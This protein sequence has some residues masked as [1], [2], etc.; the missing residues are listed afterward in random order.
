MLCRRKIEPKLSLASWKGPG[1]R[2]LDGTGVPGFGG[3]GLSDAPLTVKRPFDVSTQ[4]G[5]EF[6]R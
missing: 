3:R 2:P 6:A 1:V 4:V 5:D